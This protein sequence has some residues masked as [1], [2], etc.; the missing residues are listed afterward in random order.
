MSFL[1]PAT[2]PFG[3]IVLLLTR[4]ADVGVNLNAV[5][6]NRASALTADFEIYIVGLS[7]KAADFGVGRVRW[8]DP[9]MRSGYAW[10]EVEIGGRGVH[11]F[12]VNTSS[13]R[14]RQAWALASAQRIDALSEVL[15]FL[16]QLRL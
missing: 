6:A 11:G 10:G 12:L 16:P 13:I 8:V 7:T 15:F 14:S 4:V 3:L 2:W 9:R 5:T 1:L